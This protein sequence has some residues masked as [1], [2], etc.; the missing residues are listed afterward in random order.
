MKKL[1]LLFVLVVGLAGCA[2]ET[3]PEE[4]VISQLKKNLH[5]PKSLDVISVTSSQL[6]LIYQIL[7]GEDKFSKMQV[8]ELANGDRLTVFHIK[9]RATNAFGALRIQEI[10][11][12]YGHG[13][14]TNGANSDDSHFG[15]FCY[16]IENAYP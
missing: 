9:Y 11:A 8:K 16:F 6:D 12:V 14:V 4:F 1:A 13:V 3:T 10:Y 5:D 7:W 15:H 2:S